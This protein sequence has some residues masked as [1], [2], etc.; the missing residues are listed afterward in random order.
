M[1]YWPLCVYKCDN[2]IINLMTM[3]TKFS[4]IL[5][6]LALL[7]LSMSSCKEDAS[8]VI[9]VDKLSVLFDTNDA[10]DEYVKF[11]T[12]A[13]SVIVVVP[14]DDKEWCAA[15]VEDDR[16]RIAVGDNVELAPRSTVIKV[17]ADGVA[18]ADITVTQDAYGEPAKEWISSFVIK[19]G[20]NGLKSDIVAS[21]NNYSKTISI[22]TD[23]WIGNA[24]SLVVDFEAA[25]EV[26]VDDEKQISGKSSQSFLDNLVYRVVGEDGDWAYYAVNVSGPMFT[27]LP[28]VSI[29]IE[30]NR[31]VV[32]K[33][34]KLPASFNLM[35]ANDDEF[36]MDDVA[37][38][39]RGRGNSTWG[40]PKKPY[41]VDFPEKTSLFGLP[42][43]K[44]WV[45]LANYQDPTL[46]MNDI[47]FELGRRFG[48]EFTHSSIFVEMFVNGIYRGNYQM[49]EQKEIGK[50]RVDVD[51]KNGGFLLEIDSYFDEDYKFYSK[52][53]G[54][55]VM[56][57][58]PSLKSYSELEYIIEEFHK[59]ENTLYGDNFPNDDFEKYTDVGS[60]IDF[61]LINEIV[62][63]PELQHPKSTYLYKEGD[64][65]FKWG[66]LWD[67]DWAFGFNFSNRYFE[68]GGILFTSDRFDNRPGSSFFSRFFEVESFRE[69][70]KAR[71]KE[72]KP[73]VKDIINYIDDKG[74]YLSKSQYENFS[75]KNTTPD[76][77]N[78]EYG[79]LIYQ[80]K[81][82]LDK[83]IDFLDSEITKW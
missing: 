4:M 26:Y 81:D 43:A 15:T 59:F 73:A 69:K 63:N 65:K 27:G 74:Q 78:A 51:T 2:I 29:F 53:F 47:A 16:I 33:T 77:K 67:F 42:A 38:T 75:I 70:Y 30:D 19:G 79:E 22:R 57:A 60:L 21:I 20:I 48:L 62:G 9:D 52:Y 17:L 25:G 61:I 28:V 11:T 40:M 8:I 46:I 54:L 76:T 23:E 37:M 68:K 35:T 56:V 12:N 1:V 58:D 66:P 55:P 71:W 44:K 31:E 7:V 82:W 5:T 3:R 14:N 32:E 64:G 13:Q 83:R 50:G 24:K 34:T 10:S 72:M 39:I 49:T 45:F 36:E 6:A 80:M 18:S 41:R